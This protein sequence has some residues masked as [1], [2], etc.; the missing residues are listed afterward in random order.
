M[1]GSSKALLYVAMLYNIFMNIKLNK[2][3]ATSLKYGTVFPDAGA[4]SINELSESSYSNLRSILIRY[5][6][7]KIVC[8]DYEMTLFATWDDRMKTIYLRD[9][10]RS[11]QIVLD[12][13][14][15]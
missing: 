10:S 2:Q 3:N 15:T 9:A 6:A 13:L 5:D 12:G 14:T 8:A 11:D 7:I 4:L 1:N